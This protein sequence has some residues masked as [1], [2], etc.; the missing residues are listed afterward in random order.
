MLSQ[1]RNHVLSF[2]LFELYSK[3][4]GLSTAVK[5]DHAAAGAVGIPCSG[6]ASEGRAKR[7][8]ARSGSE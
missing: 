6:P 1:L 8:A 4:V 5:G 2:I 7:G 3:P